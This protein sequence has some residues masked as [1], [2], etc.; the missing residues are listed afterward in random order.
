MLVLEFGV[1]QY[2]RYGVEVDFMAGK[3][4]MSLSS[5]QFANLFYGKFYVT[6]SS[7]PELATTAGTSKLTT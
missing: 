1:W 2:R 6:P 5:S 3:R 7:Y 4:L